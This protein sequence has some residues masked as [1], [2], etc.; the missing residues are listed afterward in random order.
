MAKVFL[1]E[2]DSEEELNGRLDNYD[3][4]DRYNVLLDEDIEELSVEIGQENDIEPIV[5]SFGDVYVIGGKNKETEVPVE[6]G[7]GYFITSSPI[8]NPIGS[9]LSGQEVFIEDKMT[10]NE[11]I[12]KILH[13]DI[14]PSITS[15]TSEGSGV[16]EIGYIVSNPLLKTT[17]ENGTSNI[18]NISFYVG[19]KIIYTTP[20]MG[21]STYEYRY[22]GSIT[23]NTKVGVIVDYFFKENE[24]LKV[25]NEVEYT[26][27]HAS[28][29]GIVDKFDIDENDIKELTKIIK[30]GKGYTYNNVVVKNQRIVYAYPINMGKLTSI[31]DSNN[32]EVIG[33]YNL[34][35]TKIGETSY[36]VYILTDTASYTG[37]IYFV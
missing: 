11:A 32:F 6:N 22:T 3:Q 2:F 23:E 24:K 29:C 19:D 31:K 26:F 25:K 20:Y 28:Y 8:N 12:N 18:T 5:A 17:I 34:I 35:E 37:K 15:F 36:Y 7:G 21:L 1:D 10:V 33:S 30:I 16:K 27:V 14:S 13:K 9:F 4:E